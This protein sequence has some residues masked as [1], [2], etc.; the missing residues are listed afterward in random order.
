LSPAA[1]VRK[2]LIAHGTL[3]DRLWNVPAFEKWLPLDSRWFL[4]DVGWVLIWMA[5]PLVGWAEDVAARRRPGLLPQVPPEG[6]ETRVRAGRLSR[7][8]PLLPQWAP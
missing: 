5:I 6:R 4:Y 1:G 8:R 2:P 3:I 7:A